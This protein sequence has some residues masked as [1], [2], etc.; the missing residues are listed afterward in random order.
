MQMAGGSLTIEWLVA[1][2]E[3]GFGAGGRPRKQHRGGGLL[4]VERRMT[5]SMG[6]VCLKSKVFGVVVGGKKLQKGPKKTEKLKTL[7]AY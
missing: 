1:S 2:P 6:E 5:W 4:P 3:D 7:S